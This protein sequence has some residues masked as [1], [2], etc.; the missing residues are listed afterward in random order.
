LVD[1]G[2]GPEYYAPRGYP[3]GSAVGAGRELQ[4][5]SG[6]GGQASTGFGGLSSGSSGSA[7]PGGGSVSGSSAYDRTRPFGVRE[8]EFG[9]YGSSSGGIGANKVRRLFIDGT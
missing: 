2:Y 5:G 4:S 3:E 8:S 6:S 1:Y 7:A 9:L